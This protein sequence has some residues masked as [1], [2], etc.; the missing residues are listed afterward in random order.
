MWKHEGS[1]KGDR[2]RL[3]KEVVGKNKDRSAA[4]VNK[5]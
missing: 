3:V 4:T 5:T 1:L 2:I